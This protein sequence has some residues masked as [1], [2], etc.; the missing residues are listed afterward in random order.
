MTQSP[1]EMLDCIV[2]VPGD[3]KDSVIIH[4]CGTIQ[5]QVTPSCMLTKSP[6]STKYLRSSLMKPVMHALKTRSASGS[7]GRILDTSL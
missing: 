3:G 4:P 7:P 6:S 2:G 1:R 5:I